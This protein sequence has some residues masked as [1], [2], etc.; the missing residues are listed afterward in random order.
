MCFHN[1]NIANKLISFI[2]TINN[3]VIQLKHQTITIHYRV[4]EL[5]GNRISSILN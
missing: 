3:N 2:L 1:N 4:R 5:K